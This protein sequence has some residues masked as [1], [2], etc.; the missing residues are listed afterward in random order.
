[1]ARP[2]GHL[3]LYRRP[4]TFSFEPRCAV[5]IRAAY[6]PHFEPV[7]KEPKPIDQR[8]A[9][10]T[11]ASCDR[12]ELSLEVLL[13]TAHWSCHILLNFTRAQ[14]AVID[15]NFVEDAVKI[16]AAKESMAANTQLPGRIDQRAY[17]GPTRYLDAIEIY[18]H[19]RP[20]PRGRH[21]RP[22]IG[23]QEAAARDDR[24]RGAC[25]DP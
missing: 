6:P 15:P 24:E 20:I 23:C 21:M 2:V 8:N 19:H 5:S 25:I 9:V 16:L 3:T 12:H 4:A 11:S 18:P 14:G 10:Y 7:F 17:C 22:G 13:W 1:M